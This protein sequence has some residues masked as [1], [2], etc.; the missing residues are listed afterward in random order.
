MKTK[1]GFILCLLTSA[2]FAQEQAA[3]APKYG[4]Q[5]E[6]V[7]GLNLTQ[8]KFDNWAQGGENSFAWQLNLNFKFVN[9]LEKSNWANSGK[10]TYGTTKTGEQEARKSIDEIKLESVY[11]YKLG[12][13]ANPYVAATGETQF[14]PGYAYSGDSKTQISAFFDPAFFRES[15]GIG[16]KPNDIIQTRAGASVKQTLASEE[17]PFADDPDTPDKIE[18]TKNE[19]G[20]ES[21][22]DLNWKVAENTLLTSKLELF[23]TFAA[24]D[25][26]DVN[27]DNVLT[28][29]ISKY[30]NM[31]FNFKLF[32]DKDISPKR[33]IKQAFAFGLTYTFL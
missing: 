22:T 31:N 29:K 10:L 32:Y 13:L 19:I 9:D 30:I 33:Q 18:T 5:K 7:G 17:Y 1:I 26:T 28:T 15:V 8:N 16:V 11:T 20:A 4:W 14:A 12:S 6:M 3:E 24:F 23:T 2:V 25:E 21:V 27:W